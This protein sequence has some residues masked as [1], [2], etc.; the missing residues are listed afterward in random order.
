MEGSGHAR[1]SSED[2]KIDDNGHKVRSTWADQ[3]QFEIVLVHINST[4]ALR[5]ESKHDLDSL[6]EAVKAFLCLFS[7]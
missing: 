5:L 4:Q 7:Q 2:Y 1:T 3:I 6:N